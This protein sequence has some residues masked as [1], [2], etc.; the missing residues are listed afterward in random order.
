VRGHAVPMSLSG[1]STTSKV[2][3]PARVQ[4]RTC[5]NS[6]GTVSAVRPLA[7]PTISSPE[8]RRAAAGRVT[9][10]PASSPIWIS[11]VRFPS[12]KVSGTSARSSTSVG[13]PQRWSA[14][15]S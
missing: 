13:L 2:S 14:I 7:A 9:P 8:V 15:T 12:A 1:T 4:A 11:R 3:S 5:S 6:S 10:A